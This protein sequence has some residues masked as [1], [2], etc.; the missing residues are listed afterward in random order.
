MYALDICTVVKHFQFKVNPPYYYGEQRA[1]AE[2]LYYGSVH[3]YMHSCIIEVQ[4][5]CIILLF[6][7]GTREAALI[8]EVSIVRDKSVFYS[9]R[10]LSQNVSRTKHFL[11][12]SCHPLDPV[13]LSLYLLSQGPFI[14]VMLLICAVTV[15]V[16]FLLLHV[17]NFEL[18]NLFVIEGHR[19]C[20][21]PVFCVPT[22]ILSLLF[23]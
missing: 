3:N 21:T 12:W 7:S 4:I 18:Q 20:Y 16:S 9:H 13:C 6:F 22:T 5:T 14:C 15:N 17:H 19:C 2:C 10:Y 1:R 23:T 8:V 11:L